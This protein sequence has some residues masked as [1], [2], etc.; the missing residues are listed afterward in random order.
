VVS[1][2]QQPDARSAAAITAVVSVVAGL[3]PFVIT[4]AA[5]MFGPYLPYP[6]GTI[7]SFVLVAACV[8]LSIIAGVRALKLVREITRQRPE[9]PKL[10]GAAATMP[11]PVDRALVTLR[12][13]AI[14]GIVLGGL[15]GLFLLGSLALNIPAIIW[16]LSI[17]R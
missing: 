16:Q 9:L 13:A 7:V 12:V 17:V 1:T 6:V 14:A 3:A 8:A 11:V 10:R 5:I 2:Q 15:N 4:L